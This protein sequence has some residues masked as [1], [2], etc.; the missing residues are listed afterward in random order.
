MEDWLEAQETITV[1]V[2][3]L[4]DK[5]GQILGALVALK[6]T[7]EAS[8]TRHEEIVVSYPLITRGQGSSHLVSPIRP[9]SIPHFDS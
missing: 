8:L 5:M 9:S 1:D 4:K 7:R 6:S 2:N 3:P